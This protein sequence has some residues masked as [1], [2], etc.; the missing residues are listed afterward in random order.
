M[1]A[2]AYAHGRRPIDPKR[3][4]PHGRGRGQKWLPMA[5][6]RVLIN[7]HLPAYITWQRYLNNRERLK[8]NQTSPDSVGTVRE[9]C[10]LLPGLL[11]CGGCGRKM[12]VSYRA[13][14]RAYYGCMRHVMEGTEH[15]CYGLQAGVLDALIAQQVQC[16]LDPAAL[17]LSVQACSDIAQERERLHNHWQQTL[18]RTQYD[19]DVAQRRYHHVDPANRLVAASLERQWEQ[20]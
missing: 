2:G 15:A 17:E 12:K 4:Y 19:V 10:A 16:A 6:W 7:D 8:Q 5:Q 18:Q 9:G 14:A 1:Y 13:K 20:A 3:A 11:V